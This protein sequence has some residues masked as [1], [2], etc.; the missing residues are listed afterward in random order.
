MICFLG[1][2]HQSLNRAMSCRHTDT[3][4][5]NQSATAATPSMSVPH[6]SV[7]REPT[8]G[9]PLNLTTAAFLSACNS[10]CLLSSLIRGAGWSTDA[11]GSRFSTMSSLPA[12]SVCIQQ[13]LSSRTMASISTQNHLLCSSTVSSALPAMSATWRFH[14]LLNS[15]Q[16]ALMRSHAVWRKN[17]GA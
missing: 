4:T 16:R 12:F 15:S 13:R 17:T 11:R 1:C 7:C 3:H 5:S 2:S 8:L 10:L 14:C 6:M 9:V